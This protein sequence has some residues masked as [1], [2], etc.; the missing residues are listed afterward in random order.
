M[1]YMDAATRL[2]KKESCVL[3]NAKVNHS[4]QKTEVFAKKKLRLFHHLE[5]FSKNKWTFSRYSPY[6]LR[7][8]SPFEEKAPSFSARLSAQL[9]TRVDRCA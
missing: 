1:H 2:K 7:F 6:L 8:L 4:S 3:S 5:I 9:L